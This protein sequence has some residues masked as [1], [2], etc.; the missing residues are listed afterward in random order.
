M[1]DQY[2]GG[3]VGGNERPVRTG[4]QEVCASDLYREPGWEIGEVNNE[5]PGKKGRG[6]DVRPICSGNPEGGTGGGHRKLLARLR[7]LLLQR[8]HLREGRGVSD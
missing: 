1:S 2:E 4:R 5:H 8:R 7:K 6:R 3:W